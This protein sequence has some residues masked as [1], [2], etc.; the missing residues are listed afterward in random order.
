[1]QIRKPAVAGQ[2]YSGTKE[3]C[4]TE[5]QQCLDDRPVVGQLPD[6]IV[7]G[8][9]PH[10]GW[11][12][13]GGVAG[14]VFSAVQKVH[15]QVD[16]FILLGAAHTLAARDISVYKGDAWETPLGQISIDNEL[17]GDLLKNINFISYDTDA[18]YYEHS[19]EVQVPFI[20]YLF[21][22][23]E[24]LPIIVPPVPTVF[25]FADKLADFVSCLENKKIVVIASTDL[26]HYGPRYGFYPEG[27][28]KEGIRWAKEVNDHEFIENAVSVQPQKVLYDALEHSNAC[29]PGAAGALVQYAKNLG[30]TKGQLLA[31]TTSSDIMMLKFHEPS[32]ESVGYAGIIF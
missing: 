30:K 17:A 3:A 22:D 28:G 19:I 21:P 18:H 12:F 10:A 24:I 20:Q 6:E 14:M 31:H 25:E 7:A 27:P 8:I 1:M 11:M 16:T 5:I 26:T 4:I 23:A 32:E 9:V 15:E 29:G 2:F 13:S